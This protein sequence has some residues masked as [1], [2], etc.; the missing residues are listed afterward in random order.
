[1]RGWGSQLG[2]GTTRYS[3]L[4][5]DPRVLECTGEVRQTGTSEKASPLT[6]ITLS[7]TNL[8]HR[9]YSECAAESPLFHT[10]TTNT[11]PP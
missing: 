7:G 11:S 3:L 1:M 2:P 5:G 9:A 4:R 10:T 6:R 8:V